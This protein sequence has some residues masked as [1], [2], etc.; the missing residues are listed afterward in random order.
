MRAVK[1]RY[2]L[3]KTLGNSNCLS[4]ARTQEDISF[5]QTRHA[6]DQQTARL[7]CVKLLKAENKDPIKH[8]TT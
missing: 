6:T 4:T 7:I 8:E 1:V 3:I 5:G 2:I